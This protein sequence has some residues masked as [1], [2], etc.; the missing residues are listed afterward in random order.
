MQFHL[1]ALGR[2]GF[3]LTLVAGAV[4]LKLVGGYCV[5]RLQR[6]SSHDAWGV[7]IVMNARGVMELVIASIAFRA[8]LVDNEVF[9]ALLLVGLVTTVATPL[10]LK[11]WQAHA[12]LSIDAGE[13]SRP[14]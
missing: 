7:G 12:P 5:G 2:P 6:M 14:R 9:S 8:A 10:M 3:V 11:R 4:L 13:S 1:Q